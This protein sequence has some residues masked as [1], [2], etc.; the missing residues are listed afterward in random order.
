[1]GAAGDGRAP[2]EELS[3]IWSAGFCSVTELEIPQSRGFNRL[4]K[5]SLL[6]R[7]VYLAY[8]SLTLF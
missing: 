2:T 3:C 6:R 1:M 8:N 5:S 4:S 7:F